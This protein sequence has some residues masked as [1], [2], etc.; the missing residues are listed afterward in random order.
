MTLWVLSYAEKSKI[1]VMTIKDRMKQPLSVAELHIKDSYKGPRPHKIRL[2]AGKKNE[3]FIPPQQFIELLRSANRIML[4]EGGDP[5]NEEAFLEMLKGFQLNADR[6][7][8]CKH[9]WINKRFNF[10]NSKSIKYHDELICA[11]CAKEELLRAIRS[12]GSQYGER[13]VDFFEQVLSKT[14]DL[15]RTIR[16]LSPERLD[17]EF[18]RY[19]TIRTKPSEATVRIKNLPL[20]KKFKE[21]LL[22]KSETLLPVQALSVEAGLLEGKNQ[23]VVSATATGKTLIGEMAGI[24]NL[25]EKKGKML[26]LVPLVALANQKY[27]QFTERYSKLGLTTSIK[28]GAI[29]IKT[30]Q[31]VKMHTSPNADI[32]VGTYEGVDH[33]L[34]SGNADFLGKIGTVVIDEVHMLEDQER[35]HRLDGLIGRLRYVAPEAQFIYLS[36]TV[37]NPAAYA[38]KLEARLVRYEH[39]PVP[40]DR[41]LLFC[42]ENEK[43]N[44]ISQLAKEE[45]SML[46]SKNHRG[47]TIVFTNSRRNCHKLAGALSIQASPYHAGLSQYERKKVETLFAKGELP[48]IVT[49][50]ALAAGVDFPA[51]QVIFESLAMGIDWISVQEFMQMSGR[52]GRPDYHDRGIVVLMPVPGKSYSSAQSDTEEEVAIKLLQGEMLSAGVEYGEAEQLEE[53]LASVAVTSSIQD[54]RNIHA[55]MFGGFDLDKQ[56]SRLQSYR[57]LEKKGNKV[58]LTRFG[59]IIAAHFLPVSKAFLIRDAVL[60]ENSSLKIVTNL[61]FFDAAYFKYA[62]QIGSSL[63]VNMPSRVFQGAALDIVFDGE[64]LSQLDIKIRELM[65]S[66]ASDFL[67]CTCRD[68]PYCGCAEQKFSE[69]IIQLRMEG[70]DPSQIIKRLE[71]K[72]GISAYQG[73]VFGYLDGAVRNLDAVELIARVHSKKEVAEEAKKLKK[74]VQG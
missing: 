20:A 14:R 24:Q 65:L 45:Y 5:A 13:S 15:D 6:V 72:Y 57:F 19:D 8:I 12:A 29:L 52:A 58:A 1:I 25:L 41:H 47:Q 28:I 27:D 32:I 21:M 59:K 73:D 40:I 69:K 4:A 42:Q 9:C 10:V 62:N 22:Q 17:P 34:R 38:K 37:V 11:D 67:T 49:T 51:S 2:L 61:E 44:L 36:A 48:V 23:F 54:L 68:S 16:M 43:A 60:A 71:D 66:F 64:S 55:L 70:M 30:S 56:V 39:R 33:M 63:H 74:K 35:G 46:S 50:A 18:T 3:E 26:Y 7:K 31:R 53:V